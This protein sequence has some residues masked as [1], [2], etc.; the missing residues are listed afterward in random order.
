MIHPDIYTTPYRPYLGA[1]KTSSL[2]G[3]LPI[4]PGFFCPKGK[5][6]EALDIPAGRPGVVTGRL[7][8]NVLLPGDNAPHS[9]PATS[10]DSTGRG[11]RAF[12]V[13]QKRAFMPRC[14]SVHR[15]KTDTL[16]YINKAFPIVGWSSNPAP[17]Y[18]PGPG[19]L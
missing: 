18:A 16:E 10:R 4:S 13:Q 15:D 8:V 12:R 14:L 3:A 17:T 11:L 19:I 5:L 2:P 7:T 1:R 6:Y 9:C